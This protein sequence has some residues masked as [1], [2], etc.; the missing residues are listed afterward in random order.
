MLSIVDVDVDVDWVLL[1]HGGKVMR[2]TLTA[3][4]AVP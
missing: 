3:K 4:V 2:E 1:M